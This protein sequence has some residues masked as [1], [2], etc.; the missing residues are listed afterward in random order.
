MFTTLITEEAKG[1]GASPFSLY[2]LGIIKF[3]KDWGQMKKDWGQMKNDL[4]VPEPWVS[5]NERPLSSQNAFPMSSQNALPTHTYLSFL[6]I[7]FLPSGGKGSGDLT[8]QV[9][10]NPYCRFSF[11]HAFLLGCWKWNLEP[12]ACLASALYLDPVFVLVN[13]RGTASDCDL[14]STEEIFL[15]QGSERRKAKRQ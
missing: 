11:G 2:G 3:Q 1:T 6:E 13:L 14:N 4:P 15:M 12:C 5:S 10:V 9:L 7:P 8:C